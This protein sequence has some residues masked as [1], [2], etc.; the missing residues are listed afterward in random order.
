MTDLFIRILNMSIS[1]GWLVLAVVIL[2][3][4]LKKAPRWILP[5][6]WGIVGIRLVIPV[7]VT[8]ALS[9]KGG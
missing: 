7:T 6:L 9:Q 2:R 8:G 4:F 3:L 1:A 5:L